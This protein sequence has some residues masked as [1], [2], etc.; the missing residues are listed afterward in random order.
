M[1]KKAE[2]QKTGLQGSKNYQKYGEELTED[3]IKIAEN[4]IEMLYPLK[5]MPIK[6]LFPNVLYFF[7]KIW[8]S[9]F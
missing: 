2:L 1:R 4:R 3:E 7:D 6:H 8:L 5:K 9:C